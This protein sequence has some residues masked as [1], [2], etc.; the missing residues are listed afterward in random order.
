MSVMNKEHTDTICSSPRGRITKVQ[1]PSTAVQIGVR[2]LLFWAVERHGHPRTA[3]P[4]FGSVP[5]VINAAVDA[6]CNVGHAAVAE[7][8]LPESKKGWNVSPDRVR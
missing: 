6:V 8:S 4:G 7:P 2:F 1:K 3:P 5:L